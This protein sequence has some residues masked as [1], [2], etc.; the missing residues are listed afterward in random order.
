MSDS[1]ALLAGY[2]TKE[3]LA[4][5]L[6]VNPRTLD[7]WHQLGEGPPRTCIGRRVLYRRTSVEAWLASR[8]QQR[9]LY[10]P[11]Q[12]GTSRVLNRS[13]LCSEGPTKERP[14]RSTGDRK[15]RQST[16]ESGATAA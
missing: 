6:P 4:T 7:R 8:E 2:F 13:L 12:G 14:D 9:A 11:D 15:K 5:Q 16:R 10:N 1:D 3:E